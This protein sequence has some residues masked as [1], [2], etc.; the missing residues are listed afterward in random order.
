VAYWTAR[1]K[2]ILSI[3]RKTCTWQYTVF[4]SM[5]HIF[6]NWPHA[7]LR[8][9]IKIQRINTIWIT[10]SDNNACDRNF[11]NVLNSIWLKKKSEGIQK[12]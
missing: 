1:M 9:L 8:S 4:T 2:K 5:C 7:N 11:Q 10:F 12:I 6:K 3:N